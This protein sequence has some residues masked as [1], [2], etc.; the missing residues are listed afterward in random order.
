MTFLFKTLYK[1]MYIWITVD[2][3]DL[4]SKTLDIVQTNTLTHN[5]K[6][7]AKIERVWQFVGRCLRAMNTEQYAESHKYVPY[8]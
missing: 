4:L 6:N 1:I 8:Q 3:M 7:N 2:P 5:P